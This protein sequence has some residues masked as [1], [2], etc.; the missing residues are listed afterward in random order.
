[1]KF[2]KMLVGI[3]FCVSCLLFVSDFGVGAEENKTGK[4][5]VAENEIL[6]FDYDE[7]GADIYIVDKRTGKIWSNVVEPTYY[8]EELANWNVMSQ[9]MTITYAKENGNIS[10]INVSD[11]GAKGNSFKIT[12]KYQ[13]E[14]LLLNVTL[15]TADISFEIH[16]WLDETGFN[17]KIPWESVKETGSDLLVNIQMMP[18]FGAANSEEA[19][20]ILV[21]DGSGTIVNYKSYDDPNA[22][23][24]SYSFYGTDVL[25][26]QKIQEITEQG[27][28][29]LMLPVY[30]MSHHD[31]AVLTAVTE[32]EADTLLNV[33]PSGFKFK[34]LN[35]A[36]LTFNY[37]LYSSM[38]VDDKEY[39][40]IIPYVNKCDREV[41]MFFMDDAHNTYSD[42]AVTYREY[43]ETAEILKQTK[44]SKEIPLVVDLVMGANESGLFG[45][46][47]IASTTYSQ[48]AKIM[49]SLS[50]KVPNLY[51][52]LEGW[53]KGGYDTAPTNPK[54]ER[55]FGGKKGWNK[56]L[57]ASEKE[58][59]QLFL[60]MDYI[61]AD[62][63]TGNFNNRKDTVRSDYGGI[64]NY[65]NK[66]LLNPIQVLHT[67]FQ[68]AVKRVDLNEEKSIRFD[69]IGSLLTYDFNKAN[70]SSRTMMQHAYEKVMKEAASDLKNVAVAG[71]NQYVLPYATLMNDIPDSNSDY[72]FGD[73]AVPFYQIVVHGSVNYTSTA[74]N[75]AYDLQYQKL[76][77][78][79]TG[80]IPYFIVT[81]ESP[82]VLNKTNY[83]DLFSSQF[84]VWKEEMIQICDEFNENLNGVW[85]QKIQRHEEKENAVVITYEDGSRIY[86]NY[87]EESIIADGVQIPAK[88]YVLVKGSE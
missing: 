30:G 68:N 54:L 80:S 53:G 4:R 66:Y 7:E 55:K 29:G 26:I 5:I 74:G 21:P 11:N 81:Y 72:Y 58:N 25:D 67:L 43:L 36:Y 71:G 1:M 9:L 64:V 28:R 37:R 85:N 34:G 75:L 40:K 32:G 19:G 78:I 50:K 88:D 16:M 49:N 35:R 83:N 18:T 14:K 56:L 31:G 13:K 20:Y 48:A 15:D 73:K 63:E 24:Y 51:V 46:K 70:P 41:K 69:T 60:N 82:I 84:S 38:K 57:E 3:V 42:M 77:W 65:G 86:I 10:M 59:V 39:I 45:N 76:K 23:L 2:K 17:Y 47:L 33:A 61:N 79:E 8:K 12:S 27:Y 62:K 44:N 52:T 22:K 6:R 87:S